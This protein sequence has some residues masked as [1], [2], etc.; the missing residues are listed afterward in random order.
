MLLSVALPNRQT[1]TPWRSQQKSQ[2]AIWSKQG[3]ALETVGDRDVCNRQAK[4]NINRT[5]VAVS[6][7]SWMQMKSVYLTSPSPIDGRYFEESSI[8]YA[9]RNISSSVINVRYRCLS[10]GGIRT[11]FVTMTT[12]TSSLPRALDED[13]F[14][15]W[16]GSTLSRQ[17]VAELQ[18]QMETS[19]SRTWTA[20]IYI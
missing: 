20:P 8:K 4:A 5:T 7:I 14:S 15:V 11:E 6:T 19:V 10:D 17:V 18:K 2:L 9:Y 1:P 16:F 13:T 3:F 12:G